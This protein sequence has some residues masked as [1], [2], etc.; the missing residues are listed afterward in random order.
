MIHVEDLIEPGSQQVDL[1][2]VAL[3]PGTHRLLPRRF[4]NARESRNA[5]QIILPKIEAKSHQIPQNQTANRNK[6]PN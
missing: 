6:I 4:A 1:A 5:G 3:L 2:V